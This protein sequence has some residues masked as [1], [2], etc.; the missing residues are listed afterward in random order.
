MSPLGSALTKVAA[1]FDIFCFLTDSSVDENVSVYLG[2]ADL[3]R[4][5]GRSKEGGT[6]FSND[7]RG[8]M[9]SYSVN[10]PG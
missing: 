2:E 6:G 1:A 4:F 8:T 9:M 10:E 3:E 7:A 5:R